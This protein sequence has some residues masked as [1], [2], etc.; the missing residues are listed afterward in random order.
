MKQDDAMKTCSRMSRTVQA[1]SGTN[2]AGRD[3]WA[4]TTGHDAARG[5]RGPRGSVYLTPQD[6]QGSDHGRW[7]RGRRGGRGWGAAGVC[8]SG[9]V[10]HAAGTSDLSAADKKRPP[11]GARSPDAAA[12]TGTDANSAE[13]VPAR[14]SRQGSERLPLPGDLPYAHQMA[15]RP[16][17]LAT[18]GDRPPPLGPAGPRTWD[19]GR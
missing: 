7:S 6:G 16:H 18:S 1:K 2:P 13:A 8:C 15:L 5:V 19:S 10:P 4:D 12:A 3:S 17:R 9:L 11:S 14:T